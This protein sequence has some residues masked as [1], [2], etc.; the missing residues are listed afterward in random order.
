MKAEEYGLSVHFASVIQDTDGSG[1]DLLQYS[2]A[3]LKGDVLK[4]LK[5]NGT[6]PTA[7]IQEHFEEIKSLNNLAE[8]T[9]A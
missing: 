6:L 4:W 8:M 1:R 5:E 2:Y 3:E 7:T 9:E